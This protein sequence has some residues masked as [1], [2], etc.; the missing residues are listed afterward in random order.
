MA[1]TIEEFVNPKSMITP[2]AAAAVVATIAGAFFSMFGIVLPLSLIA[3]SFFVGVMVFYS[4]EFADPT[5]TKGAKGFFYILNSIIIFAMAT[6]THAVLDK[7]DRSATAS[8]SF[9][10]PVYAQ[11]TQP[12][13]PPLKQKRPFFY[14]WTK[15]D[16][17]PKGPGSGDIGIVKFT[18]DKDFG[19]LKG[20]FVDV[21][22][23]TPGY[24]VQVEID[25]SK[26]SGD[27]KSV[28]WDLPKAYFAMDQVMTTDKSR[29]FEMNIQAWKPFE[30]G[31]E[32]ELESGEK[33][34]LEKV[35]TFDA[36]KK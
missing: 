25:K 32:I 10:R 3:L 29:N 15:G 11:E 22:L 9:I 4:K 18:V 21:G 24:K 12:S 27:V 6:G 23:A 7:A 20:F 19:R 1:T 16:P 8:V 34:R 33:L 28:T 17:V 26:V 14:D 31:A 35:I 5:M 13:V 2:G 36:I 30:I